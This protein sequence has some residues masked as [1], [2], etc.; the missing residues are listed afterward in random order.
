MATLSGSMSYWQ[1][2]HILTSQGS[3]PCKTCPGWSPMQCVE[4]NE[5]EV[6]INVASHDCVTREKQPPQFEDGYKSIGIPV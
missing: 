3:L 5:V 6:A 2:A 4:V 1:F